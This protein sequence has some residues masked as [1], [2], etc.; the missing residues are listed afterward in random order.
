V[1]GGEPTIHQDLPQF[2]TKIKEL[3]YLV[4]LDTNGTNPVM[5]AQLLTASLFDYVAMDIK[6]S[7]DRYEEVV[8]V[9]V[10]WSKIEESI[11]LL[12]TFAVPYEFRTTTAPSLQTPEDILALAALLQGKGRWYLQA[13]KNDVPMVDE[14]FQGSAGYS[15]TELEAIA[16]AAA[17]IAG[18]CEVRGFAN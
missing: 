11:A 8:G 13:L 1:S 12:K 17:Q 7:P 9:S 16:V 15:R 2:I 3:G 14:S 10:A 18:H 5:L 4:K 6:A